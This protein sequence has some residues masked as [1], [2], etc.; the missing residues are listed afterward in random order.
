M[1]IENLK[2]QF[3]NYKITDASNR[4]MNAIVKIT[5]ICAMNDKL[6]V[7]L[8]RN[9]INEEYFMMIQAI[10]RVKKI[11]SI[12]INSDN[13]YFDTNNETQLVKRLQRILNKDNDCSICLDGCL[14][15]YFSCTTCANVCCSKCFRKLF[16]LDKMNCPICRNDKFT[17]WT[18]SK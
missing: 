12:I 16:E 4:D 18:N 13:Y 5:T 8:N 7:F 2:L 10:E 3:P 1:N 9:H 15:N 11:K 14:N 17:P 6:I